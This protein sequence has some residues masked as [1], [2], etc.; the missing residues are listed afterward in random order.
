M[1]GSLMSE[2]SKSWYR[3]TRPLF[4]SGFE[5]DEFWVYGQDGFQEVLDSFIGCDVLLY[6][7]TIRAE[8]QTVRAI[9]QNKTSDVFNSTTVRQILCNIGVLKCGQYVRHEGMLWM[10]STLPDNNR[11]YEKAVLWK[12]RHS[13]RFLSPLTGEIVEYPVYSTNSTQ[14]GTGEAEKPHMNV[15]EDQHLIYIPYNEET[16][17]LDDRFR[18]LM[19]KRKDKPTAYRITRVDPVS[20]AVGSEKNEDGLIQWAVLQDQFNAQTDSAELMVADY[21]SWTVGGTE[22]APGKGTRITLTDLDGDFRLACGETKRICVQVLDEEGAPV[23][24]AQY[25]LEYDFGGAASIDGEEDGVIAV[26]A[27]EDSSF[28]GKKIKIKAIHDGSGSEAVMTI[29]IVNW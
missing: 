7:K 6:D 19:D 1:K 17:L 9:V 28:A 12:C 15:G 11:I 22:E 16:I 2:E 23:V 18:F 26:R 8:P 4:N 27:C 24:P 5:D 3:M 13:I 29:Q 14:Y 10:V 25:R 20:F 21:D